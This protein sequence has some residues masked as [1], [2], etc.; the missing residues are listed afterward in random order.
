MRRV[1]K[2]ILFFFV[3]FIIISMSKVY[4][5]GINDFDPVKPQEK[6]I[7]NLGN[8]AVNVIKTTGSILSVIIL[9]VLGIKYMLGSLEE[10]AQ[11]KKTLVPYLI[12]AFVLFAGSNL[13]GIIYNLVNEILK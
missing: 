12:G 4:G 11:Y 2:V 6:E 7:V 10:K 1:Y 3:V 13:A 5:F 9:I 8:V